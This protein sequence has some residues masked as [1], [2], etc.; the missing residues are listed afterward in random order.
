MSLCTWE[1]QRAGTGMVWRDAGGCF[2]T[3]PRSRCWQFR[4]MADMSLNVESHHWESLYNLLNLIPDLCK[5]FK[6]FAAVDYAKSSAEFVGKTGDVWRN[7]HP[8]SIE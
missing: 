1:N 8:E 5:A 3:F 6:N 4:H 2:F 7:Y